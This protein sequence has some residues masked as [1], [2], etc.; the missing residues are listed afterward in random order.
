MNRVFASLNKS[1]LLRKRKKKTTKE[2]QNK[3][4][5]SNTHPYRHVQPSKS[6]DENF[7]PPLL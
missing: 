3:H 5:N 6:G 4:K 2:K 7:G 1:L